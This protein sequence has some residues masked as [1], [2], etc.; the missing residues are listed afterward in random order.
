MVQEELFNVKIRVRDNVSV[1]FNIHCV[2]VT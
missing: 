2:D 1:F